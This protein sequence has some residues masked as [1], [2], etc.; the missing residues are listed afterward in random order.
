M[1]PG[2]KIAAAYGLPA[3]VGVAG[4]EVVA[5]MLQNA[6]VIG[7]E[8]SPAGAVLTLTVNSSE[9]F[10]FSVDAT[11]PDE[12]YGAGW[13]TSLEVPTKNAVYDIINTF[14]VF[15]DPNADCMLEWDDSGGVQECV[16]NATILAALNALTGA[17]N[18][19]GLTSFEIP[20]G[21][22][23]TLTTLG[24][25]GLDTNFWG[26]T[27]TVAYFDGTAI[28]GL[29]GVVSTEVCTDQQVLKYNATPDTWTC[30]DDQS[31]GAP[32][33]DTIGDAAANGT[34]AFAA[35]TNLW[36][37]TLDTGV[38]F[39]ISNTDADMAGQTSL[40]KLS[41]DDD[42][43]AEIVW[44][45]AISDKNGTPLTNFLVQSS[46]TAASTLVWIGNAGV[47]LSDNGDGAL[48]ILGRGNGSDEDL[49]IDLDDT[50]NTVVLSSSTGVTTLNLGGF[51]LS[52]AILPYKI[53]FNAGVCQ[54]AT[55][56]VGFST[57]TTLGAAGGC[58]S[59]AAASGDPAYG[60]AVFPLGGADTELHGQLELP[61]DWSGA[62]DVSLKW[63]SASTASG[64]VV[65]EIAFGC[66]GEDEAATTVSFNETALAAVANKTGATLRFNA[67]SATGI[68]TT[69][70]AAGETAYF[71]IHRDT[72][73]AGDTLDQDVNLISATFT[74]RRTI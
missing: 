11:V 21:T 53:Q 38:V 49:T 31:A 55:A 29:V 43:G 48:T 23:P 72:D 32:S 71:V 19:G 46:T 54:N 45:N 51:I 17:L 13:D 12:A 64:D 68:T 47:T 9:V 2:F 56:S 10:V 35:Y 30:E 61:S 22:G 16:E 39:E 1:T 26:T 40:L 36:T 69:G 65:W 41:V 18:W 59:V 6:A 60:Y 44:I 14:L 4:I 20:N 8:A 52:N 42:A 34:I 7:W 5:L 74:I 3:A 25:I 15:T 57:P 73:T 70:C 33:F 63:N 24:Q 27:G 50:A 28:Y 67:S 58:H 37:S 66:V 62:V